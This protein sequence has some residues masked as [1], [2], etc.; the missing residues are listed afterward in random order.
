MYNMSDLRKMTG[1]PVKRGALVR[2]KSGPWARRMRYA[3]KEVNR[4]G[5]QLWVSPIYWW[6]ATERDAYNK[7]H[8][9]P[10]NPV[11]AM[12]GMSGECLCGAYAHKGE[13]SLV[14]LVCPETH[15]RIEA[16]ELRASEAGFNW[17]WEGRPPIGGRNPAQLDA[18]RPLCVGCE[19][20]AA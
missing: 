2:I 15:A 19:K 8:G 5:S 18:F 17:G 16:L 9:L 3:G 1:T 12:L 7:A 14:K 11:S 10:V 6:A 4:V 20:M 13:K